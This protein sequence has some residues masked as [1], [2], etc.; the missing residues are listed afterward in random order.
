MVHQPVHASWLNQVEIYLS[1]VQ[2]KVIKP[3]DFEDL[4]QLEERLLASQDHYNQAARLFDW[5]YTRDNLIRRLANHQDQPVA[6][7][8]DE[9]TRTTTRQL[10]FSCCTR[11]SRRYG[12]LNQPR[13]RCIRA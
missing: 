6:P 5:R 3:A 13:S 8:P 12:R 1:V 2:R 11:A 9:L 7:D 10:R 4:N